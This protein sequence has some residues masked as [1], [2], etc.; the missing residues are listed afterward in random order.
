MGINAFQHTA[1]QQT[2]GFVAFQEFPVTGI[3]T[4]GRFGISEKEVQDAVNKFWS[5]VPKPD[6]VWR[7]MAAQHLGRKGGIAY[8]RNLF[9]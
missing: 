6:T 4:G 8:G 7:H 9:R 3:D 2:V 1:F 5:Y